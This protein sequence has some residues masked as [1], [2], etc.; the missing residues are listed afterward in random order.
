MIKE[1]HVYYGG[2]RECIGTRT[3]VME[4]HQKANRY[5]EARPSMGTT[6]RRELKVDD[7]YFRESLEVRPAVTERHP[8]R[9]ARNGSA[10]Y[11]RNS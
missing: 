5:A 6:D 4:Q 11:Q 8:N 7:N 1:K 9:S 3:S 10:L 2:V